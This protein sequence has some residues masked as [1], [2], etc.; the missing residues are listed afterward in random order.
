M[1]RAESVRDGIQRYSQGRGHGDLIACSKDSGLYPGNSGEPL[2]G[3]EQSKCR[4]LLWQL[5][6]C[7]GGGGGE[8][9]SIK[10]QREETRHSRSG[11]TSLWPAC[12]W[13]QV[14]IHDNTGFSC[15]SLPLR[16]LGPSEL[17]EVKT[18]TLPVS[19][20]Q[21]HG[22]GAQSLPWELTSLPKNTVTQA[23]AQAGNTVSPAPF[24]SFFLS[25]QKSHPSS[26]LEMFVPGWGL[27]SQ[28]MRVRTAVQ[29]P[30][31][32]GHGRTSNGAVSS[33]C[34]SPQPTLRMPR[35]SAFK[36][37]RFSV[38][39]CLLQ[40]LELYWSIKQ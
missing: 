40:G 1:P 31:F 9:G 26:P 23:P 28:H 13:C 16:L 10:K 15:S 38:P 39:S 30:W 21:E 11:G 6:G 27:H 2:K 32:P 19:L 17:S 34:L 29:P 4:K 18:F 14:F 12:R 33:R 8:P 36:L 3:S 25:F 20:Q 5:Y 37:H 22:D 35:P 24:L 7:Q